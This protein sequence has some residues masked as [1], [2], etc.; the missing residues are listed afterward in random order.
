MI[1]VMKAGAALAE[2]EH[3]TNRID[4]LG[5]KAHLSQGTE[6]TIIGVI[7]DERTLEPATFELMD[8]VE[9]TISILPQYKLASREWRRENTVVD[10]GTTRIGSRQ[11]AM[12]AGPCSVESRGQL[13]EAAHA[14]KEAGAT[15]L[16]GGAYKPR[17]SPYSF[18]GLGVEGLEILAEAR[19]QTGL[20]IVTEVMAPDKVDLVAEYADILQIGA[21]NMQNYALLLAVGASSR[22]VLLKRGM[23]STIEE[24][25]MSAEY[26][27]SAGNYNVMLCERGIRTF[28][29]YTRNTTDINAIPALKQLTHLPVIGDPSHGTGKWALVAPVARALVAAGA[30]GLIIEV[31][32]DPEHA[33]SD[34]AQS[35]KPERFA[36]LVRET[37]LVAEAVG[38]TL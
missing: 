6:R 8:G 14:V 21:R 34:G 35:L 36:Q 2:V 30:D 22:P 19:E 26:I 15:I 10:V 28:E 9:K 13:L 23:M 12:M 32:H 24:L 25:L 38:R 27:M 18:Q 7:G 11:L 5:F 3:V 17:S 37:R 31:H 16:R 1:I 33:L 4:E 29:T 20:A